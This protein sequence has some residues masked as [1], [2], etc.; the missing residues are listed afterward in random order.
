MFMEIDKRS[1]MW[2]WSCRFRSL[3]YRPE[4][5]LVADEEPHNIR[6]LLRLS[7]LSTLSQS[8][9]DGLMQEKVGSHD[10]CDGPQVHPV[11][12]FL[13]DHLTEELQQSLKQTRMQI[14]VS[15]C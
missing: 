14:Q 13:G 12:L 7:F 1:C 9:W 11:L 6:R 8:A 15:F 2:L 5:V 4:Q 3:S 10:G